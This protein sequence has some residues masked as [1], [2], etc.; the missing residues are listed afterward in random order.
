MA[1]ADW[2][3]RMWRALMGDG[4]TGDVPTYV[5]DST[6]PAW[7]PGGSGGPATQIDANGTTLNIDAIADGQ[8]LVRSGTSIIGSTGGGGGISFGLNAALQHLGAL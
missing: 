5:D 2:R 7:A 4:A 8:T 3:F 6:P 1:L